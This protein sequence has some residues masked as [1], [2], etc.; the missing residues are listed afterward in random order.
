[1]YLWALRLGLGGL[2]QGWEDRRMA[3]ESLYET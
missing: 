2:A 1:M 3:V